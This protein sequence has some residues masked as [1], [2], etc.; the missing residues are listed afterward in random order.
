MP[1]VLGIDEAG[2]GP[3]LG[4][5]VVGASLWQVA[6]LHAGANFW[7]PL[8]ACV[9]RSGAHGDARLVVDDSKKVY[10]RKSIAT[11]ERSVLAFARAAGLRATTLGG[12]L[13]AFGVDL[14]VGATTACPWYADLAQR[15]PRDP[16]RSACE[17]VAERLAQAMAGA[18]CRCCGLRVELVPEDVFNAQLAQTRNKANVELA[19]VLRL[20][21]WAARQAGGQDL[22]I[23]VD[24]LGGRTDYRAL[25]GETFPDRHVHVLE[26]QELVSRYRLATPHGDWFVQFQVDGDSHHLPIAL[27]SMVAKY[28]RELLME[29]F[30]EYWRRQAPALRPTAGYY[31]DAR[32]FIREIG[33]L[34]TAAGLPLAQFVRAR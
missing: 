23:F 9:C 18:G 10:D 14:R 17:G 6:P 12:L 19:P 2:Y 22:H 7:D 31:G 20:M 34:A 5:L 11:L 21:Q 3:L 25:L 33:P 29:R 30:N 32:R 24:R 26:H 13:L 16:T 8:Q 28:V 4:P 27:A 15:V 1:L